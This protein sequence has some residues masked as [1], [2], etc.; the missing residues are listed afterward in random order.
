MSTLNICFRGEIRKILCGYPLL[1][2]AMSK[3]LRCKS[4]SHFCSKNINV[5]GN[6]LAT[7]VNKFFINK[8]V[9]ITML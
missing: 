3:L 9:K 6:T 2:V 7:T 8:L 4:L 1:S 5:F